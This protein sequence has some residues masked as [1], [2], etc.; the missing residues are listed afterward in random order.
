MFGLH[1]SRGWIYWVPAFYSFFVYCLV[2]RVSVS[3]VLWS[4]YGLLFLQ[5]LFHW[6]TII[7]SVVIYLVFSLIYN[8]V[9]V[10]CNPPTDP[11]WI[12]EKQLSE[13]SFYLL[14]LITPAIA[15]LPRFEQSTPFFSVFILWICRH[16][17]EIAIRMHIDRRYVRHTCCAKIGCWSRSQKLGFNFLAH[18]SLI[19]SVI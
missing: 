6:I 14:C 9:C 11:Y 10:A 4:F 19:Y 12:M 17:S 15:L 7:G 16:L 13:P 3:N 8:A 1:S 2:L 18:E 5:T